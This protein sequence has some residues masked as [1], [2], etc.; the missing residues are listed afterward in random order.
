MSGPSAFTKNF[1]FLKICFIASAEVRQVL[2]TTF[3]LKIKTFKNSRK[4]IKGL[5]TVGNK[6][7]TIYECMNLILYVSFVYMYVSQH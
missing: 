6:V 7:V 4:F 3:Q 2:I 5:N 1:F